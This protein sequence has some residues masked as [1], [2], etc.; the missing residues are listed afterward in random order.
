MKKVILFTSL[1]VFSVSLAVSQGKINSNTLPLIGV[2][3]PSFTAESTAG[4]VNFPGDFGSGWKIIFAHPKD[5]TPVC[6]SELL[7]L[8]YNQESFKSL[9]TSILVL[10]TDNLEQHFDWKAALEEINYKDRGVM[11]IKFPLVS[12]NSYKVSNL[13]GMIHSAESIG[14]N[15]RG[16]FIIDPEN[17]VRS[18]M[19][20]PNEVGRNIDELK[21]TLIALQETKKPNNVV[22]PANWQPGDDFMVPVISVAERANISSPDSPYYQSSWFMTYKKNNKK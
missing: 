10:S 3:A 2:E 14:E 8:A 13:Y 21:R 19:Y 16:V 20:Y 22:T 18:I 12:D 17:K 6:S 1:C 5:F 11:S 15:I 7:E 4:T 9:N